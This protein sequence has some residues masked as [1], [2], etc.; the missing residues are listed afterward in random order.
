MLSYEIDFH[1]TINGKSHT[2]PFINV[3]IDFM[4]L[5]NINYKFRGNKPLSAYG[6]IMLASLYIFGQRPFTFVVRRS[7]PKKIYLRNGTDFMSAKNELA[8]LQ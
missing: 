7:L 1:E 5:L 4:G 6:I 8:K 3:S 2:W